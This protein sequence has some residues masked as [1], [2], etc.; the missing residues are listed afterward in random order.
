MYITE[1]STNL[2]LTID[3]GGNTNNLVTNSGTQITWDPN[4]V[5]ACTSITNGTAHVYLQNDHL[6]YAT[7]ECTYKGSTGASLH[8]YSSDTT[9]VFFRCKIPG[10]KSFNNIYSEVM[11]DVNGTVV[12]AFTKPGVINNEDYLQVM[13]RKA[14]SLPTGDGNIRFTFTLMVDYK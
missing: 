5:A 10:L 8:T 12:P 2:C 1:R 6:I 7:F 14:A 9:N 3:G 11:V 4:M 13:L